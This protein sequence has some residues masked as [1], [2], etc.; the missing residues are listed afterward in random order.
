[1]MRRRTDDFFVI[2]I[3][4]K[5]N[6]KNLSVTVVEMQCLHIHTAFQCKTFFILIQLKVKIN[7]SMIA[8]QHL[9]L[10]TI[11]NIYVIY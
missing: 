4:E 10:N 7:E 8:K 1:M 6:N 9:K 5:K 2:C 3:C 11:R